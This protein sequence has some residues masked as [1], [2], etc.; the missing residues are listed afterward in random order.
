MWDGTNFWGT[1]T[2]CVKKKLGDCQKLKTIA[3]KINSIWGG[4]SVNTTLI[5]N[6]IYNGDAISSV[7]GEVKWNSDGPNTAVVNGFTIY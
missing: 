5:I 3:V 7:T 6:V 2:S 4:G 1:T